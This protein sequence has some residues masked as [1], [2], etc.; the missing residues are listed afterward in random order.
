M[1]PS[2]ATVIPFPTPAAPSAEALAAEYL[3]ARREAEAAEARAKALAPKLLAALQAEGRKAVSV[4]GAGRVQLVVSEGGTRLDQK[5]AVAALQAAGL[6]VPM[7]P[8]AGGTSLR[9]SLD[10]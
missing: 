3:T 2:I 10:G 6:E 1:K 8:T 4:S 5:A 7:V 9:A